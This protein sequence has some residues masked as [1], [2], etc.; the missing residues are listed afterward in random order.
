MEEPPE[1]VK[2]MLE[3]MSKNFVLH[4]NLRFSREP[5]AHSPEFYTGNFKYRKSALTHFLSR[6]CQVFQ[7]FFHVFQSFCQVFQSFCQV[8]QSF[9]QVFQSFCQ[10]FQ[11]NLSSFST[12]ST[13]QIFCIA[14][15]GYGTAQAKGAH[16]SHQYPKIK[17]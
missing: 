4:R 1:L 2:T 17:I 9:C 16:S 13:C 15:Q 10:V 12:S 11:K 6:N 14:N 3:F 7:S 5:Q 8:F